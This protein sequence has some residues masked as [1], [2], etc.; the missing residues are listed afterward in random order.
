MKELNALLE[1]FTKRDIRDISFLGLFK[2]AENQTCEG[3]Y[4]YIIKSLGQRFPNFFF[5]SR[6]PKN[7]T[8]ISPPFNE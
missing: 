1:L 8:L 4:K 2:N 3:K 5:D 6:I 7:K